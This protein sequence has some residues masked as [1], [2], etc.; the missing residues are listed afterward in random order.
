MVRI[1]LPR[2]S[3]DSAIYQ[4]RTRQ[5]LR[6]GWK[7]LLISTTMSPSAW[8]ATLRLGASSADLPSQD[9]FAAQPLRQPGFGL[10]FVVMHF[11]NEIADLTIRLHGHQSAPDTIS[12]GIFALPRAI[13]GIFACLQNMEAFSGA[14]RVVT[15]SYVRRVRK[16]MTVAAT[17]GPPVPKSYAMWTNLFDSWPVDR[18]APLWSALEAAEPPSIEAFVLSAAPDASPPLEAT[19]ASL[20]DQ[21]LPPIR[22]SLD[23]SVPTADYIALLQAGEV[24]PP[25]ALLLLAAEAVRR[26]RPAI[27]MA[28]ED[29][30]QADGSRADPLFK[31]EPNLSLICSGTLSRGVWLI[32]RD[33]AAAIN[34]HRWAECIRIAAWFHARAL[35]LADVPCR[36][37]YVLTHRR[38]DAENAPASDLARVVEQC[39]GEASIPAVVEA[40]FPMSVRRLPGPL[41]SRKVS[42]VIPSKLTSDLTIGCMAE[43]L[44]R[45]C[46]DEFEM[47]VVVT[48]TGPLSEAQQRAKARLCADKRVRVEVLQQPR[49]NYSLA[50]NFGV[51]RTTGDFICLLNDDVQPLESDWLDR[52]LGFFTDDAVGIVGAKL[53]YPNMTVQHGGVIM[54][55]AGLCEH[56]NRYLPK[57][58]PGY[59]WRGVLDQSLSAVTGACMLV[60]RDVFGA[61]GGLDESYPAGF[62]DVDFCLRVRELGRAVVLANNVEM[63]H[64]ETVTFGHHYAGNAQQEATDIQ[65]MRKRWSEP[66]RNDPFHN[67]NLALVQGSEW[68]PAFPPRVDAEAEAA[69]ENA[70]PT[71]VQLN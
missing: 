44:A 28:D 4:G 15:G 18:L 27:L 69:L 65:R 62:N 25:H 66:I 37:P 57:G 19:R 63:I 9:V 33:L 67:P 70:A 50:N 29:H 59:A 43:V 36:V 23:W 42:I 20:R 24:L 26:G 41:S 71:T 56:A 61:V 16:A 39:L 21:A 54:G 47:L 17:I 52:M 35:G 40:R 5:P 12:L 55:P 14:L 3:S 45:T 32:R 49:F 60:R 58:D 11:N 10:K 8:I 46:H 38:T 6:P 13:A 1:R 34:G 64:H 2:Y 7:L 30:I 48:Q 22:V 53:Y 51:A 68:M 31:P